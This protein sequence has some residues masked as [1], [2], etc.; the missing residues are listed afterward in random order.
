M[1]LLLRILL[2]LLLAG[3][4]GLLDGSLGG[5]FN[6][7]CFNSRLGLAAT[8]FRR[9]L[10]R[11]LS[12]RLRRNLGRSLFLHLLGPTCTFSEGGISPP[13]SFREKVYTVSLLI[14]KGVECSFMPGPPTQE[15]TQELI[16][17]T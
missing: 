8:L 4:A 11:N 2:D 7:R 9:G 13:L 12:G 5:R 6:R 15:F 10:G 14:R 17:M 1:L 3:R 16:S